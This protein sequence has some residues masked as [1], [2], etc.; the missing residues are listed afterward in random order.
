MEREARNPGRIS[1]AVP[2][3]RGAGAPL[4][5]G[6]DAEHRGEARMEREARNPGKDLR[7]PHCA[8]QARR[9][10]RATT[11]SVTGGA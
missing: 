10:M 9:F 7:S 8:A 2:A 5:A 4:H 11:P 6:Y 3:L 1:P